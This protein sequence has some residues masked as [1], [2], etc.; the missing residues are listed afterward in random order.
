MSNVF[1]AAAIKA[2]ATMPVSATCI[3]YEA[4]FGDVRRVT[5]G[6][7]GLRHR[8]RKTYQHGLCTLNRETH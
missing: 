1:N 3:G 7:Y 2:T 8:R 4:S 5:A 6:R